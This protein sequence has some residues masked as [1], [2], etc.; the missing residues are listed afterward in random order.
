M[1]RIG[2]FWFSPDLYYTTHHT[3]A[4]IRSDGL[5]VVGI[6]DFA[7]KTLGE[8]VNLRLSSVGA[9]V[10]QFESLGEVESMKWVG[11]IA[12]PLSGVIKEVNAELTENLLLIINDS[13]GR[14]WLVK[15]QPSKVEDELK[16]LM[17][18]GTALEW[19]KKEVRS[20]GT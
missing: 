2:R 14:G 18:G 5:V 19:F 6:D 13:Y 16:N 3:W 11:D 7:A 17:H 10:K 15:L 1:P 8:I 12:S 9:S 20:V 4:K